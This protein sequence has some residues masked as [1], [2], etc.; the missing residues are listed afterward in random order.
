MMPLFSVVPRAVL[1]TLAVLLGLFA[2]D[3]RA[4]ELAPAAA[5][6]LPAEL[7]AIHQVPDAGMALLLLRTADGCAGLPLFTGQVAAAAVERAWRGER[8][9]RPLTHELLGD[10]LETT[11]WK[12]ERLVIDEL[13]D[14][15]FLA[16]LELSS[17]SSRNRRLLDT[18]PS[19]GLA[20][21]L[22][23]GAPVFIARQVIE[24]AEREDREQALPRST[25]T[26]RPAPV[27]PAA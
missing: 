3:A 2:T 16:A 13:R 20:I 11:G 14:G 25:L 1:P 22:R 18:R 5:D 21:A 26:S 4:R 7:I 27:E 24:D 9:D 8:P 6:L 10:L 19:D 17:E 12:I 15:Q 23:V